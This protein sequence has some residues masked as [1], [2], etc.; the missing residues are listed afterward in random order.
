MDLMDHECEKLLVNNITV[1]SFNVFFAIFQFVQ[2]L[3]MKH[4]FPYLFLWS[5]SVH[6]VCA[7]LGQISWD[8]PVLFRRQNPTN[9]WEWYW[10]L[11]GN[12]I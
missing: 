1:S 6:D 9:P 2:V 11:S 3:Q 5:F 8:F 7:S 4:A 10:A 12:W